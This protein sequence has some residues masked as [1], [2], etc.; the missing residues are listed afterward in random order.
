MH[1]WIRLLLRKFYL[2]EY[3]PSLPRFDARRIQRN[4][5]TVEEKMQLILI[6]REEYT[7]SPESKLWVEI[8]LFICQIR[9][10]NNVPTIF[11]LL[12]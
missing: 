1:M 9:Q 7:E 12:F 2:Y 3:L 5:L 10:F 6:R 4:Q 11:W 8:I